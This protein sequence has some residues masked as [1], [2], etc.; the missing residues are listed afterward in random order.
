MGF[1]RSRAEVDFT[2]GEAFLPTVRKASM[3]GELAF[4]S[5]EHGHHPGEMR[6]PK[7]VA[8][9]PRRG[10]VFPQRGGL[11]PQRGGLLPLWG[12]ATPPWGNGPS[13]ADSWRVPPGWRVA[14]EG[15]GTWP[16]WHDQDLG[17]YWRSARN[18]SPLPGRL[19]LIRLF[20]NIFSKS[21]FF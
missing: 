3:L 11:I 4:P 5:R 6:F 21:G 12:N 19:E 20:E 15:F 7:G 1:G 10:G 8:T 18:Q 14:A 13:T 17:Q 2:R 9:F 16:A